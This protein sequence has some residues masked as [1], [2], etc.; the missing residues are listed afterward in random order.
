MLWIEYRH[1]LARLMKEA[2]AN[3]EI[4][5]GPKQSA[6]DVLP[7]VPGHRWRLQKEGRALLEPCHDD[8][9]IDV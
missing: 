3:G 2:Q 5:K 1:A 7:G 9:P 4:S 6:V 8:E